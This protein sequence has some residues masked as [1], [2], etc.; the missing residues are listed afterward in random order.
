[1]LHFLAFRGQG[2]IKLKTF[3]L[4]NVTYMA[5]L[6]YNV[7]MS[8]TA[9]VVTATNTVLRISP[10]AAGTVYHILITCWRNK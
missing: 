4:Q 10:I 1:M 2:N 8:F 3:N 7:S 6:G 9:L 5:A